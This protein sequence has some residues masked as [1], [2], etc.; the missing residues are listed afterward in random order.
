VGTASKQASEPWDPSLDPSMHEKCLWGLP[1]HNQQ[2]RRGRDR[3]LTGAH[4]PN[5]LC[6]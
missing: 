3:G 1:A 2:S 4:G 6:S 5:G